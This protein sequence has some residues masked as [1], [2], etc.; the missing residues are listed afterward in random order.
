MPYDAVPSFDAVP[1]GPR[2]GARSVKGRLARWLAE[3]LVKGQSLRFLED[4]GGL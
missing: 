2:T 1:R 4:V 3:V